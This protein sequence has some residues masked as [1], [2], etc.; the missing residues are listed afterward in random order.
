MSQLPNARRPLLARLAPLVVCTAI[1]V[2]AASC[3][4]SDDTSDGSD[5]KETTTSTAADSGSTDPGGG[6]S[7]GTSAEDRTS[8]NADGDAAAV[9]L[10]DGEASP[11]NTITFGADD[12]FSP[13]ELTVA[14]GEKSTFKAGPDAGTH[15]VRFGTSTDT[16]TISGGLIETFTISEPGSYT[17]TEDLTEATM[18]LTVT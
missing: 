14:V 13:P 11:E 16:Y 5:K 8:A 15:A 9:T 17:V 12:A 18:T 7:D 4:S 3:S 6:E 10:T 2:G 1:A